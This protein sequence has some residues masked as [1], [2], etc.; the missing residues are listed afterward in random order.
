[1]SQFA[2]EAL[3]IGVKEG[4]KLSLSLSLVLSYFRH[5]GLDHLRKPLF[6][7]LAIVFAASFGVMNM[8]AG[9]EV[10]ELAVKMI[11]YSFGLLYLA[12]LGALFQ[13]TGTDLL[14][15]LKGFVEKKVFLVPSVLLVTLVYS[16]P[17]MTGASL[18]VSDLSFMSGSRVLVLMLAGTGLAGSVLVFSVLARKLRTVFPLGALFGLPQVLLLLAL[19]KLVAGGVQGFAELS[20]IPSVQAGL[21][22]M[23][24]DV[25]HQT[26]VMLMVPDHPILTTTTWNFIGILFGNTFGLWLSLIILVLP[27]FLFVQKHFSE[28]AAVP[29]QLQTG[30]RRRLYIK[31][32]RDTR[33]LRSIP[34]FAFLLV[35]TL[36][37][38][39]EKGET[40]SAL[41]VPEPRPVAASG[42]ELVI[43]L[44]SASEDLLDGRLH[45]FS[46]AVD[47]EV[48]RLLAVKK[49]DGTLSLCLDACEICQPDGYAQGREH[50]VCLYCKTPIP[51]ETVGVPG[52]CNPIPLTAL[53]TEKDVRVAVSEIA[54]KWRSVNSAKN[55]EGI[56][57]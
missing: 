11:G 28:V 48:F 30:A 22:K 13:A 6:S 38:F 45:K 40:T 50:V 10:R 54:Q 5:A 51:F 20:L 56:G 36:V 2:P 44:Q 52:G 23:I 17:E 35:I 19:L 39:M 55:R 8:T 3:F 15:P 18:Y 24:H 31:S 33:L 21:M 32:F 4:L 37:W 34:V 42:A 14:G 26:L 25:V 7:C 57:R 16:V 27:L 53:V 49:P 1:M 43:P 12:S 41:Y 29:A 46:I 9:P 47:G